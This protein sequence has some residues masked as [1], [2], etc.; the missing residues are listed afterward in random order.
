MAY[1]QHVMIDRAGEP[2]RFRDVAEPWQWALASRMI[3]ALD[4][5]AGVRI[6]YRGPRSF[7]FTLPRGHDKTSLIGRLCSWLLAFTRV[8]LRAVAAA[9]DRDQAGFIAEF[10]QTEARLNPWM[11][12]M[13]RFGAWH[14]E[15]AH[16]SRLRIISADDRSSFGL[17][18]DFM[19]LD[20]LT[21]WP[22]RG[23]WDTLVSGREKRPGSVLVVIT[24]AGLLGSWQREV[25][26]LAK[27]SPDWYV[28]EA[29]GQLAGWM[30]RAKVDELRKLVP[31]P[32]AKRLYDNQW[33]TPGEDDGFVTWDEAQ[34][35]VDP[36]LA[37]RSHGVKEHT[38]YVASL[39]YGPVR[40]RTVLC[41]VHQESERVVVDRMDV[42]QGSREHRVPVTMIEDWML[43]V[44]ERF[45]HPM[46]VVD[47]YNLEGTLQRFE[48][49]LSLIRFE[50][51]AGK[52]NHQLAATLRN[53]VMRQQVA[54]Y[55]GAGEV[56][57]R[58][59]DLTRE[60][61]E[62]TLEQKPYGFRISH[63][64]NRHDDRV[65]ALG[66]ATWH[67]VQNRGFIRL[68]TGDRWF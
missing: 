48:G 61:A 17:K 20:E 47:P 67:L 42:Y 66:M 35:C 58:G 28:Y 2:C 55:P 23:L 19:V 52:T 57:Q 39:D 38:P 25:F 10:M 6:G 33:I 56:G 41:V 60:M 32:L 22:R 64:G 30:D 29:P 59:D 27:Q 54:W 63:E 40:D 14:V 3:P 13:L 24:N 49:H 34:R 62:V 51:R 5:V 8:P 31:A 43:E 68:M 65:V 44:E 26:E 11:S 21:H 53:L 50:P 4:S 16:G 9:S 36:S 15:G 18:E 37:Y 45:H 12:G 7:W 46:W 1:L